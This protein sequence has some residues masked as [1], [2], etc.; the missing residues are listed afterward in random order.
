MLGAALGTTT[1]EQE[2]RGLALSDLNGRALETAVEV[3]RDISLEARSHL[4]GELVGRVLRERTRLREGAPT[5]EEQI[6]R[7]AQTSL[8][9][10]SLRV[11]LLA[12]VDP[13]VNRVEE[14]V[15]LVVQE[16]RRLSGLRANQDADAARQTERERIVLEAVRQVG[17]QTIEGLARLA[18]DR[19]PGTVREF[20][21][22]AMVLT[23]QRLHARGQLV[24]HTSDFNPNRVS[25]APAPP[26]VIPEPTPMAAPVVEPLSALDQLLLADD[27]P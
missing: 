18:A 22:A 10:Q 1:L 24:L 25:L 2:I 21:V 16:R 13:D 9:G 5:L 4:H 14:L 26:E 27:D 12:Q 3:L 20:D 17:P 8:V 15:R 6:A 23:I 19:Q 7:I 11:T